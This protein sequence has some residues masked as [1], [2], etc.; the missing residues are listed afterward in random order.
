MHCASGSCRWGCVGGSARSVRATGLSSRPDR[1]TAR[2]GA[3]SDAHLR[4]RL[5]ELE[6]DVMSPYAA[7]CHARPSPLAL[8]IEPVLVLRVDCTVPY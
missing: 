3:F 1:R 4:L 7:R 2:G 6:A 5:T 8:N